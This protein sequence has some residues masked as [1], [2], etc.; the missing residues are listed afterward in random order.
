MKEIRLN[1]NTLKQIVAESVMRMLKE[2]LATNDPNIDKWY[3]AV[4]IMGAENMLDALFQYLD[5]DT[6]RDFIDTLDREYEIWGYDEDEELDDEDEELD[7][8]ELNNEIY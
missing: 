3:E 2:G 5:G 8:E 7:N 1:E 4:Q 6:I